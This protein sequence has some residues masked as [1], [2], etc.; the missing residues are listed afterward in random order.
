[1]YVGGDL[2]ITED[3]TLDTNL[4]ILGIA[5]IGT[6][7]LNS[8][9]GINTIDST[10][11]STNKDTGALVVEGGVGIEKQLYVGAG[12]SVG[13]GLT[14]A[15]DILP[16]ADGTRDLGSSGAEFKDLYIDGTANIDSLSADTAAIG[17]L[18][19]NESCYRWYFW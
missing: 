12:A 15:G 14:V 4:S 17:D 18:T 11:Q 6:L 19:D 5:T 2:F 7:N 10:V 9:S 1:M 16:E 8:T 13:A 3:I